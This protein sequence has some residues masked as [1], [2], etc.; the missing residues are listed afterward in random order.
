MNEFTSIREIVL[1]HGR[2]KD[3]QTSL[4]VT[5][6]LNWHRYETQIKRLKKLI[7]KNSKVLDIGCG[8]GFTTAMIK[9]IRPDLTVIGADLEQHKTWN[10]YEKYGCKYV[11]S[12]AEDMIFDN[13]S[14]DAVISFGMIEHLNEN[15][16]IKES[17]RILRNNGMNFIFNLP[18]KYSI[19]E[20]LA[21]MLKIGY[22]EK[23]YDFKSIKTLLKRYD[24]R[25][26]NIEKEFFIP[27]QIGKISPFLGEV[28]NKSYR[29]INLID[30]II[31][32]TPLNFFSEALFVWYIKH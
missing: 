10:K 30:T 16:F 31:K 9:K 14:F 12:D 6:N 7:P 22:H 4:H 20:F 19:N 5:S 8:W 1:V 24:I 15:K 26:F 29:M 28:F 23:R 21:D 3:F 17:H 25:E 18:N 27:A 13:N 11:I 2:D 32:K